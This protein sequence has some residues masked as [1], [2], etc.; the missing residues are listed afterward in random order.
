MEIFCTYEAVKDSFEYIYIQFSF[1][2]VNWTRSIT[3]SVVIIIEK[4]KQNHY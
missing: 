4:K 2:K 1:S 3:E